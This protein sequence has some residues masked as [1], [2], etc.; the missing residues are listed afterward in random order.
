M[1]ISHKKEEH[2]LVEKLEVLEEQFKNALSFI[3][4]RV[5][6]INA[7]W[8]ETH[9]PMTAFYIIL[10]SGHE[11]SDKEA[12]KGFFKLRN[13]Y[14]R[15]I[16]I[17]EKNDEELKLANELLEK[18]S[19]ELKAVKMKNINVFPS[20]VEQ[21]DNLEELKETIKAIEEEILKLEQ[22]ELFLHKKIL[23]YHTAE[24]LKEIQE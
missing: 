5:D 2:E 22:M 20:V 3:T 14:N 1:S 6:E 13:Q 21:Q 11:I 8:Q 17:T 24:Q 9:T 12:R 23:F 19:S 7:I 4:D 18:A 16:E 15:I 10:G